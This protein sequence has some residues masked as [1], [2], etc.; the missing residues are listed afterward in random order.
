MPSPDG[1]LCKVSRKTAWAKSDREATQR[2]YS[3]EIARMTV[4]SPPPLRYNGRY[5]EF[6]RRYVEPNLPSVEMVQ[7]FDSLLRRHLASEDPVYL[8][9]YV[10][11]HTRGT[12]YRT[13]QSL[14]MLPTDNAPVWW[15]HAHLH[16]GGTL[17]ENSSD[18]FEAM[19]HHFFQV[20][21]LATLNQAGYHAAHILSAKNGDVDWQMWTRAELARRM[22]VNIHPCNLF[23]VAKCEWMRS[24]GRPDIIAWVTNAYLR[25]Y[26][27]TMER[28]LADSV[29]G[30]A[31][32]S[33]PVED[34]IY[35]YG[36]AEEATFDK[37]PIVAK[38][39][40]RQR[41]GDNGIRRTKRPIIW[42]DLEGKGV[43][44]AIEMDGTRYVLPHDHLVHWARKHTGALETTS[45]AKSGS[46]SWPRATRAMLQFLQGYRVP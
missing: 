3:A 22:L 2:P 28:F 34:P 41:T 36:G 33:G 29:R 12:I 16:S 19:P 11:G 18:L 14:R 43:S 21:R 37:A 32:L 39:D 46:Y 24:G 9:R 15:T 38:Q 31:L 5:S 30:E 40:T 42:R 7:A 4:L 6:Y 23:L 8:V 20:V 44:L 27:S 45:W 26:G 13:K 17:P 1:L 35:R 25:R 10:K